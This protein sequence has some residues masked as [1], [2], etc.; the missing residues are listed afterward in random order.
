MQFL[1]LVVLGIFELP[2]PV[3]LASARITLVKLVPS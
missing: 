3:H 1:A 2:Q